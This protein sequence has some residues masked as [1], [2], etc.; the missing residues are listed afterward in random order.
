MRK[1]LDMEAQMIR[2]LRTA[3]WHVLALIVAILLLGMTADVLI[4]RR[5]ASPPLADEPDR[6]ILPTIE[7][8]TEACR[9]WLVR[10]IDTAYR[11]A[12]CFSEEEVE[13]VMAWLRGGK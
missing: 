2:R 3:D 5:P 12:T 8:G 1:M 9:W 4:Q 6:L 10:W 13:S 7:H 11:E